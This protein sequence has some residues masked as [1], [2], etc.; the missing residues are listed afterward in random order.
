MA[1]PIYRV[2][3]ISFWNLISSVKWILSESFYKFYKKSMLVSSRKAI[4]DLKRN[5]S[6]SIQSLFFNWNL[7][8]K[9]V[10]NC[11]V[12]RQFTRKLRS[13]ALLP[14]KNCSR[15][16][17]NLCWS[18]DISEIELWPTKNCKKNKNWI[19][20]IFQAENQYSFFFFFKKKRQLLFF[21]IIFENIL[22]FCNVFGMRHQ[23]HILDEMH[24]QF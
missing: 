17:R 23:Y 5:I 20:R 2:F 6:F 12:S 16:T 9:C 13:G 8:A 21:L 18:N 3:I 22:I 4:Q 19:K 1:L 15:S 10:R 24:A 7:Y 11:S 14:D